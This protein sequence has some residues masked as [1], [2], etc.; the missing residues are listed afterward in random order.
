[1]TSNNR[2][3]LVG[4]YWTST[5]FCSNSHVWYYSIFYDGIWLDH[6][7]VLV[8]SFLH[9]L[10]ILILHFLWYDDD[11]HYPQRTHCCHFVQCILCNMESF[12][13]LHYSLICELPLLI[14]FFV[15]CHILMF[16]CWVCFCWYSLYLMDIKRIP[17]PNKNLIVNIEV[18]DL[19]ISKVHLYKLES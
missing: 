11:G 14:S 12:F 2:T 10:H 19:Y 1:M 3:I 15:K 9:V 5:H 13:R 16:R 8:V 17:L 4:Y 7:K 6:I 18:L